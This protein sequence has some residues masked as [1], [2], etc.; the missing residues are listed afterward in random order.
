MQQ[1]DYD[2]WIAPLQERMVRC[3]WRIV[4]DPHDTEDVIQEVLF[5]VAQRFAVVRRHPN[6]AAL[7]LRICA[8]AALDHLRR[9]QS[10]PVAIER[11]IEVPTMD[12]E[13]P[14]S[15]LAREERR[16]AL[17]AFLRELP[18][19][20]AEAITLHALEGLEYREAALAMACSE[21]T[22][23]VLVGRARERFR[24]A[25]PHRQLDLPAEI[26]PSRRAI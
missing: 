16:L 25:F 10:E 11:A 23:R 17:L 18:E 6:P 1:A 8:N 24:E 13:T 15:R 20:E 4:R 2:R 12:W 14:E 7:L 26:P 19:R 5:R 22:V 9:R 3:V 21:S